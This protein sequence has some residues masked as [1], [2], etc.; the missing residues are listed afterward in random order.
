M[1]W[2]NYVDINVIKISSQF[3]QCS[4][5]VNVYNNQEMLEIP[6]DAT[7]KQN[8]CND[9]HKVEDPTTF[10]LYDVSRAQMDGGTKWTGTNKLSLLANVKWYNC[11]F[12]PGV[13][14]KGES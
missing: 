10:Y 2:D 9:I 4:Y 14:I 6:D 1:D 11:R 3:V 12:C 13:Q 5:N 7:V 8:N